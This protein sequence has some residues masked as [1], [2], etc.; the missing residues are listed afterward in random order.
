MAEFST[1]NPSDIDETSDKI[2]LL[3]QFLENIGLDI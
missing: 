1:V 3:D 2:K